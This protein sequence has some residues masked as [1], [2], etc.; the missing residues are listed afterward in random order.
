LVPPACIQADA[1]LSASERA[2]PPYLSFTPPTCS[3]SCVGQ[4]AVPCQCPP[5]LSS[6]DFSKERFVSR[7][8]AI[9][10]TLRRGAL[11]RAH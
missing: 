9:S 8:E 4:K 7:K 10:H 6:S 2:L 3:V 1:E 5:D 11:T